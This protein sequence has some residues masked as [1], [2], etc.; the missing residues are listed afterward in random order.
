MPPNWLACGVVTP[1]LPLFAVFQ[2]LQDPSAGFKR[3]HASFD[4]ESADAIKPKY[5][6]LLPKPSS[7]D[8][9]GF[10][11]ELTRSQQ[12]HQNIA[13]ALAKTLCRVHYELDAIS[14]IA[15]CNVQTLTPPPEPVQQKV[16]R[17][18]PVAGS[19]FELVL[20]A[21]SVGAAILRVQRHDHIS[22]EHTHAMHSLLSRYALEHG[23]ERIGEGKGV[24]PADALIVLQDA[25]ALLSSIENAHADSGE[26]H[27]LATAYR[28]LCP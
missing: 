6:P 7:H 10:I 2:R 24:A 28:C 25:A 20:L 23:G 21:D 1:A 17:P 16:L 26:F 22:L 27:L 4:E 8:I 9:P 18:A 14:A 19:S 5:T 13:N 12:Y 15:V 11:T 3:K